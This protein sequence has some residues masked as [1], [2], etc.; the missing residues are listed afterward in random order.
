[1]SE[2]KKRNRAPQAFELDGD[3]I[4]STAAP[5]P[6]PKPTPR[7]VAPA[8]E[9]Q[10]PLVAETKQV[11]VPVSAP[12][13]IEP[14]RLAPV[15]VSQPE[16]APAISRVIL[17]NPVFQQAPK[18]EFDA[19]PTAEDLPV[20]VPHTIDPRARRGWGWGAL[21]ISALASLAALWVV[22]SITSFVQSLFARNDVLGYLAMALA[23]IA[24]LAAVAILVR[25]LWSLYRLK[26]IETLQEKAARALSLDEASSATAAVTGL[27][28][29]YAGRAD[30]RWGLEKLKTH[31]NDIMDPRDRV[32][33]A[34]RLLLEPLDEE[35]TRIIARR[36]RRVTLL[37]TVAPTAALD[38]VF[39]SLQN[40]AMLRE[41]ATLYG[42][43]PSTLTSWRLARM[44]MTHLA[45]TGGL[46]LTDN[47]LQ[48][49]VG[50]TLLGRLSARF[51][52]GAINGIMT[53]R[54]GLA[55]ANVCRP[56]PKS[57]SQRETLM[58]LLKELVTF[59][60]KPSDD[61]SG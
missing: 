20:T 52:E 31:A 44:V 21:L 30:L 33:L 56:I 13:R 60:E 35:A 53:S 17:Q 48:I 9:T 27:Q 50:K 8:I 24:T 15:Q 14:V 37:T 42:G 10:A 38:I 41:I 18:I 32:K 12:P 51:G 49:V 4:I 23:A 6:A 16:P 39:V 40:L 28:S 3:E 7:I 36:A 29:L 11:P 22:V 2:Q 26:T 45:V 43:K 54:I 19:E 55:A 47:F 46:A 59:G 61:K 58:S 25:E 5:R 34:E 1:M 57:T